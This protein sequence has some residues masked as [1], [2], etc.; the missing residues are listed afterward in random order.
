MQHIENLL[1]RF[2][3]QVVSIKT[4]SGS[5]Y[6][7]RVTEITND[8]VGLTGKGDGEPTVFLFFHAIE[9]ITAM[10]ASE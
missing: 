2:K 3:G 4:A 9:S 1:R 8:F 7:G 6:E 10:E 5:V